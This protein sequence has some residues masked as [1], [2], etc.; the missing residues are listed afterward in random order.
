MASIMVWKITKHRN[1]LEISTKGTAD[2]DSSI[3]MAKA[4]TNEMRENRMK[5]A[6]VDHSHLESVTGNVFDIYERPNTFKLIGAIMGIRIGE[7][8]KPEHREHFKFLET[9]CVN[10]GFQFSVFHDRD[11]ALRWLLS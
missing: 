7:I 5:R 8:V 3:A 4:I 2:K 6:L 1:Y 9:V 11:Q 10:Q